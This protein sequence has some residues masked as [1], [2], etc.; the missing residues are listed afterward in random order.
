[1]LVTILEGQ[2]AE[3]RADGLI[4][5][6]ESGGPL[7]AAIRESFLVKEADTD[8]WRILTVWKSRE[9]LNEYRAS[10][11]T[12]GGVLMFRSAGVEPDLSIHEVATHAEN[13]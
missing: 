3:D 1:M 11:E 10:V 4:E 12:P 5:A 6:F 2:V 13:G 7:P 8:T 9:A